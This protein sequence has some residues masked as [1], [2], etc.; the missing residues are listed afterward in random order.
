MQY[1]DDDDVNNIKRIRFLN[2]LLR[3]RRRRHVPSRD[4]F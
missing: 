1:D 3:R 2:P 4:I